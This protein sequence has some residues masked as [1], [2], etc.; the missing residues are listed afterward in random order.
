M[1]T[2]T[3]GEAH[4]LDS[5]DEAVRRDWTDLLERSEQATPFSTLAYAEAVR[6]VLG[7]SHRLAGIYDEERLVG[8]VLCYEKPLG[9]YKRVVVPPLTAYTSFLFD[10]PLRETDINQRRSPLDALLILLDEHYHALSFSLHPSLSDVRAFT[11]RGWGVTPRYT[12]RQVLRKRE[13]LLPLVSKSARK[14]FK[15]NQSQ[16]CLNETLDV[17]SAM[18][19][20]HAATYDHQDRSPP[21]PLQHYT[22][23]IER[24][25]REGLA[26]L[27]S[28]TPH[29]QDEPV[30]GQ[31][32]LTLN[33]TAYSWTGGTERGAAKTLFNIGLPLRLHDEGIR[34]Y[35]YVGANIPSLAEF[36]RSFGAPLVTY[37]H[38]EKRRPELQLLRRLRS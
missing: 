19:E 8:G 32:L 14:R 15:K 22:S 28:L 26:R 25:H 27:F 34:F 37:Y 30:G 3:P 1:S 10:P 33:D 23:L 38:V 7:L 31:V 29:D 24:L 36:K 12:H 20:L 5:A 2:H 4:F 17:L 18:T 11:W 16:H 21:L 6:D 13:K 35:D 9:P